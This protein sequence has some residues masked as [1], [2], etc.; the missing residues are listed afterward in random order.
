MAARKLV[1][2]INKI[3]KIQKINTFPTEDTIAHH[4]YTN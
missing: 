1:K 2:L 4:T 3:N